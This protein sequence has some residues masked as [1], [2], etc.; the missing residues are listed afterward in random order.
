MIYT[1]IRTGYEPPRPSYDARRRE[2]EDSLNIWQVYQYLL[3]ADERLVRSVEFPEVKEFSDAMNDL[4]KGF[5]I[6]QDES[7]Y[8]HW[9]E[10]LDGDLVGD[11]IHTGR[12][13]GKVIIPAGEKTALLEPK[14]HVPT[15]EV[16]DY[17][18]YSGPVE[19]QVKVQT[20]ARGRVV[21]EEAFK[22]SPYQIGGIVDRF[23]PE[24]FLVWKNGVFKVRHPI[25]PEDEWVESKDYGVILTDPVYDD[26]V[27]RTITLQKLGVVDSQA[28]SRS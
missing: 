19:M 8:L 4:K 2:M 18:Y 11:F 28:E 23:E 15:F 17:M 24:P 14:N 25:S 3:P 21:A 7:E 12:I 5:P 1:E 27:Y 26:E 10:N 6:W 13:F 9:G 20:D 16:H 22:H